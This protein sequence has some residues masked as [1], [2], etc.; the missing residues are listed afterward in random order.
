[1]EKRKPFSMG[2]LGAP[3]TKF[4][5]L[6]RIHLLPSSAHSL[7]CMFNESS[8]SDCHVP[9]PGLWVRKRNGE[10]SSLPLRCPCLVEKTKRSPDRDIPSAQRH[11][12]TPH[13]S[14]KA[15]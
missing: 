7:I 6:E 10:H 13:L 4:C 5:L 9:D 2:G 15:T 14:G 11:L 1:M 12:G 3:E 8:S